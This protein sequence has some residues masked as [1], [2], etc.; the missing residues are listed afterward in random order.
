VCDNDF[1]L[2]GEE[3]IEGEGLLVAQT[4]DDLTVGLRTQQP[5]LIAVGADESLLGVVGLE[6]LTHHEDLLLV[7]ALIEVALHL[8]IGVDAVFLR[9]AATHVR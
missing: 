7:E 3:L 4:F 2:D 6:D 8:E 5:L 1:L 9:F